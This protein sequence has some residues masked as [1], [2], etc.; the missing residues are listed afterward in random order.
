MRVR[1]KGVG[2]GLILAPLIVFD[3]T[4]GAQ[5]VVFLQRAALGELDPTENFPLFVLTGVFNKEGGDT[6]GD[7]HRA[8]IVG[9]HDVA[10][11]DED[12]TQRHGQIVAQGSSVDWDV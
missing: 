2:L 4:L 7:D 5:R 6:G 12:A 8:V 1:Q 10:G 11:Q 9:S 3:P